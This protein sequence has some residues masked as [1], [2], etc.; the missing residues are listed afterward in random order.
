MPKLQQL[1]SAMMTT[2]D[3]HLFDIDISMYSAN[4][5]EECFKYLLSDSSIS[6]FHQYLHPTN[7][8]NRV[9]CDWEYVTRISISESIHGVFSLDTLVKL[10]ENLIT[11]FAEFEKQLKAKHF[12]V[13]KESF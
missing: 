7:Q 13:R 8:S 4:Q 3:R 12:F 5:R 11:M 10:K 1:N 9:E 6:P 2:W